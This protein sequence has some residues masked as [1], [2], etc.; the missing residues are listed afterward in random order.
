MNPNV[1]ILEK[2]S[3]QAADL[4]KQFKQWGFT[5]LGVFDNELDAALY[6]FNSPTMPALVIW[7][8][9]GQSTSYF[10]L[11]HLIRYL[12]DVRILII[13]SLRKKEIAPFLP[14]KIW[15]NI[16]YKPYTKFQLKEKLGYQS[17]VSK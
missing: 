15:S 14:Q 2:D 9:S 13:T 11:L 8:L 16:L 5:I 3:I 12:C 7:N 10:I 1:L 17:L 6:L 4:R